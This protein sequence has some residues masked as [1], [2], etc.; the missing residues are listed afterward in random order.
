MVTLVKK[1]AGGRTVFY[2]RH[3]LR[4][5]GGY[6]SVEKYLGDSLPK[7]LERVELDFF[8]GV[9]EKEYAYLEMARKK[10]V[11]AGRKIPATV[12]E[13]NLR[14]FGIRFTYNTNRIEGSTLSLRD[15]FNIIERGTSPENRPLSDVKEAENHYKVFLEML[16]AKA[17]NLQTI[18]R[19]HHDI[20]GET[21]PDV[22]G[23]VRRYAVR[24]SGSKFVPPSPAE[25]E[26]L[27][28][29]FFRWLNK[30]LVRYDPADLAGL[31]HLKLVTIHP[32]GDGNGRL[33]RLVMNWILWKN[34]Y[35]LFIIEYKNR[36]RY[37]SAL[38]K[39]QVKNN[40]FIFLGWFLRNY[41]KALANGTVVA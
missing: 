29:D 35:P 38:E 19:W 36:D 26:P 28:N 37:Y 2:V 16:D 23:K 7:D 14:D 22:A 18:L 41:I 5:K 3:N 6:R 9:H 10:L 27:L 1:E 39:A 33:S 40:P 20:F 8:R 13:K 15:T 11:E 17:M 32:F 24:I 31:A 12:R 30:N 25:V 21:K 34:N 4:V